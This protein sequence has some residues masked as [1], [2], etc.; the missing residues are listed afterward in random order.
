MKDIITN[1]AVRL[2]LNITGKQTEQ[3]IRYARLLKEWNERMNLTAIT[4]DEEIA[5]K[6]FLDS[7]TALCTGK[8]GT[9]VIDVGTGAGFPGLVLKIMKPEIELTL[10]D[11]L[12]KRINFL[13]AVSEELGLTG[14]EFIHARA[15]DGGRN[16][17]LRAGFDTVVSRAVAN[18]TTLSE[19]CIPFLRKNGY[20]LAMKGPLADEELNGARRAVSILGGRVEDVYEADIPF[21]ELHHKII[22][23]K[24]ERQTPMK[25]PR[26]PGIAAKTSIEQCYNLRK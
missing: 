11:S 20:F 2:G 3:L 21:S 18:M 24:K 1:G 5:V 4:D 23:V 8:V 10:L 25:F 26:K 9:K 22:V 17:V 16:S 13:K 6:H 19:W 15:E 12:N 14:I 7:M